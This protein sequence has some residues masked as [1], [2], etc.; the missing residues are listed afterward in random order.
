MKNIIYIA[1]PNA[2]KGTV[3]DYL[4]KNY[5]YKH[6]STGDLLRKEINSG[7][8]FGREIEKTIASGKLMSDDVMIR[9]VREELENLKD[10]AFILDG[11]PRT[12]P[13]AKS[14]DEMLVSLGVTNNVVI[15]L[16]IDY[17]LALKRAIGRVSCPNCGRSYNTY[18]EEMKPKKE[19]ICD[20]CD[21]E[22]IKRSDDNEESFKVRFD[23]Y[24]N[25]A[26]SIKDYYKDKNNL[27]EI[28]IDN[29]LERVLAEVVKEAKND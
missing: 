1:A 25:N 29:N 5:N 11:F 28:M 13:Q 4:I 15:S 23:T 21:I 17:D 22:L 6:L 16:D 8:E 2:G 3:S 20:D 18:F 19:N 10:Q 9:L 14:L 26:S 12:L 27:K 7:S 24:L